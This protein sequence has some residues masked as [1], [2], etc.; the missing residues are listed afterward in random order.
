LARNS[1]S[2]AFLDLPQKQKYLDEVESF[3]RVN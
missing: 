2:A 1:F 3:F